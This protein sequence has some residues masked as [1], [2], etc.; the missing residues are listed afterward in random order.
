MPGLPVTA[1]ILTVEDLSVRY[2]VRVALSG[3]TL[4]VDPGQRVAVVGPNG[5]GKST[6]LKAIVGLV[7]I[8]GGRITVHD[9]A[10]GRDRCVAY[11]PQR[12]GL[13]W[14]FPVTVEDVVLM[15]R[16]HRVGW[17]RRPG[18]ADH[19]AV[20]AAL[21][22]VGIADLAH[23]RIRDLSGGQQQRMLIARAL[24]QEARLVL[25]DE[26]LN[27][28]DTGS[29]ETIVDVMDDLAANGVAVLVA[30]HDL[31]LAEA[32]FD[33]VLLVSGRMIAY[34]PPSEA[35]SEKNL[36][37]A[38]GAGLQVVDG[39]DGRRVVSD[40]GCCD[41]GHAAHLAPAIAPRSAVGLPSVGWTAGGTAA[42]AQPDESR[43]RGHGHRSG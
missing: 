25:M 42:Q 15:A 12:A 19:A 38:Y 5:S 29:A 30:L 1:P 6:F 26:P 40:P 41:D 17:L 37:S 32:R 21:S 33:T 3:V 23:R 13:D 24:A 10:P 20:D 28:L 14:R 22:A 43:T 4:T 39:T 31:A 2:G 18:A 16:A 36:I 35:L 34:G 8:T 11:V 9:H 7:E 27:I